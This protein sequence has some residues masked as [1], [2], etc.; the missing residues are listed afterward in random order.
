MIGSFFTQTYLK[1]LKRAVA[2]GCGRCVGS[3][4]PPPSPFPES[5]L[6]NCGGFRILSIWPRQHNLS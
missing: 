3:R 5:L 2:L 4:R 6:E 1:D